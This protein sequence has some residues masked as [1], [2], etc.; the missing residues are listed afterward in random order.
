MVP[1]GNDR[2][3]R[4]EQIYG[5][6]SEV[7]RIERV[8]NSE[9][10][11][12]RRPPLPTPQDDMLP[13][14]TAEKQCTANTGS[15]TRGAKILLLRKELVFGDLYRRGAE[16]EKFPKSKID[17]KSESFQVISLQSRLLF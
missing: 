17:Q 3:A 4:A 13:I 11:L 8:K 15:G 14:H 16:V 10:S 6:D 1:S 12:R 7:R 2:G 5:E 9:L